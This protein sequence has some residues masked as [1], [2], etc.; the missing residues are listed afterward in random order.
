[1]SPLW[2]FFLA[3]IGITG[4]FIAANR[5]RVGWWFNI[6]AQVAWLV[7]AIGTRQWGFLLTAVAYALVYIRLLRRAYAEAEYRAREDDEEAR[8]A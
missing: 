6:A 1:M 4:L 3:T 7:Y 5:P 2:S 8:D